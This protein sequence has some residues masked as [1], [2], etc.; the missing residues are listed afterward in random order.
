MVKGEVVKKNYA[1]P[2]RTKKNFLAPTGAVALYPSL[3]DSVVIYFNE[4]VIYGA[5]VGNVVS[6]TAFYPT[7]GIFKTQNFVNLA[8]YFSNFRVEKMTVVFTADQSAPIS[9]ISMSEIHDTKTWALNN[10]SLDSQANL[11]T[12]TLQQG[13]PWCIWKMHPELLTDT[14]FAGVPTAIVNPPPNNQGGILLSF[15]GSTLPTVA[16]SAIASINIKYKVR[17]QGRMCIAVV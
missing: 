13:R 15:R 16:W 12:F 10:T 3:Y 1:R 7:T 4:T 5:G 11:K 2:K 6:Q 8:N 14:Q 9:E 17:F